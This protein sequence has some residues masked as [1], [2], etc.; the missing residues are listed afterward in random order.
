L[1]AAVDQTLYRLVKNGTI[2]RLARGIFVRDETKKFSDFEVASLKAQAFG[3]KL[4]R[5]DFAMPERLNVLAETPVE[6]VFFIDG[7]STR[8]RA[9]GGVIDLQERSQRKMRLG[10]GK[11]GQ[12]MKALWHIGK[13]EVTRAVISRATD[14]FR[15]RE[16]EEV[17][18]SIRWLPAWLSDF[19]IKSDH[20]PGAVASPT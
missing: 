17:I 16:R 15:R 10:D 14:H 19:F 11:V 6:P 1:R 2:R 12:A 18:T 9:H 13:E 5:H 3:R 20:W 8:F 4:V 7:R